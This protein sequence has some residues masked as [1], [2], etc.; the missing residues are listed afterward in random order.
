MM[1][2][3]LLRESELS[4]LAHV[5]A[6]LLRAGDVVCLRGDLGAGK[7]T[8]AR[9]LIQAAMPA[10]TEV[11]SPTFTLV[12]TYDDAG[13]VPIWHFDLYR[14][15]QAD[16]VLELGWEEARATAAALVEWP[17]RLGPYLPAARLDIVLGTVAGRDDVRQISFVPGLGWDTRLDTMTP[18]FAARHSA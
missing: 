6:P 4:A 16:E 1:P 12:Q 18:F 14:L 10:V 3:V 17:E 7:T 13:A 5:F 15:K 9:V 11:P 8:F 2:P